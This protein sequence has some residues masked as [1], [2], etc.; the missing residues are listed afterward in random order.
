MIND[1]YV[2]YGQGDPKQTA[3]SESRY[4]LR[5]LFCKED[6]RSVRA[7]LRGSGMY[8]SGISQTSLKRE[9]QPSP[10]FSSGLLPRQST[11]SKHTENRSTSSEQDAIATY[12]FSTSR[13]TSR[14]LLYTHVISQN[15]STFQHVFV[16]HRIVM[17]IVV[18]PAACQNFEVNFPSLWA[19]IGSDSSRCK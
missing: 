11:T 5:L 9:P 17:H 6:G 18:Y 15:I 12:C 1:L 10:E 14:A 7:K 3:H 2:S 8:A 13:S 19:N 4:I 16:L